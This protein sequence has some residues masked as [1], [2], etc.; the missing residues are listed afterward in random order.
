[1][2][3]DELPRELCTDTGCFDDCLPGHQEDGVTCRIER[4]HYRKGG[5]S[6]MSDVWFCRDCD[7][8]FYWEGLYFVGDDPDDDMQWDIELLCHCCLLRG[9]YPLT[10]D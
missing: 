10:D 6:C 5:V 1:M 9:G 8:S 4:K 2:R 7:G 3:R